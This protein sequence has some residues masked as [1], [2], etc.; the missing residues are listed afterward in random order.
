MFSQVC[1][2]TGGRGPHVT[3]T[4]DPLDVTGTYAPPPLLVTSG[5][6]HKK[7]RYLPPASDIL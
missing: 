6:H 3:I 7:H 2:F 5:G 4:C 1:L